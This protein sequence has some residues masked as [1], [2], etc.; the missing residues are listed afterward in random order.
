MKRNKAG[1][2]LMWVL[3]L[4][5]LFTS[6][7]FADKASVS[8]EAPPDVAKGSEIII[9][10]TIIHNANN[11]FHHVEWVKV[12][13]NKQEFAKWDYSATQMPEGATFTKELKYVVNDG[14]EIRGEASCNVH[15]SKG[16]AVLNL[17]V[18]K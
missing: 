6:S 9:R 12:W 18:K 2:F 15:G 3:S 13:I 14:V 11:F 16:P 17:S 8:I 10:L 1:L 5:L 4:I 7:A